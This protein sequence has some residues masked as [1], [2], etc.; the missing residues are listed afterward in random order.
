MPGNETGNLDAFINT[1]PDPQAAHAFL[2]R[3]EGSS[4][5]LLEKNTQ[6]LYHVLTLA[7]YSPF[8]AETLLRHPEHIGWLKGE[9][10]HNFDRVK[11][12]EQLSEELA[13]FVTRM[14]EA[15]DP[16]RLV[17]FK[18]RELLRIYL[19]DCL[20]VATL[21]E[22]TEELSNLADVILRHA[23]ARANQ[24]MVNLHGRPLTH[25]AR[26]RMQNA[27]FAIVA[28][29]KL[30]CRELNYSSDIDLLFLY[31]G[32]GDTS[33]DGR[34]RES[35]ISNKEFF[36]GVA[37]R[38]VRMIGKS[39]DEGAVYRIDLRLRPHGRDGDLVW[40]VNR[41]SDYY[42]SIAHNWERQA[43][44]RARLSAG[45]ESVVTRFILTV[46]DV[47][48]TPEAVPGTM[49]AV[50]RAKEKIDMKQAARARGFNVKLGPGGIREIE[51]IAQALQLK[52][53][54]RE[55]WVRS[56]QTLIVLAR[57]AEKH[58]LTEA[59]RARLSAAYTFLRTVEHRLQ[60]EHGAQTHTLPAA[61]PRLQLLA[62]RCGYTQT[63]DPVAQ[64][65][66][67][68][69]KHTAAVRA[70]YDRVF[71]ETGDSQP[72]GE[73]GRGPAIE[74][75]GVDD[76]TERLVKQTASRLEKAIRVLSP[77]ASDSSLISVLA[78]A[79]PS[80]INPLRS[81]RNLSA[82]AESL[83]THTGE[84]FQATGQVVDARDLPL[85]IQR[86][87]LVLSSQYLAHLLVSRPG[88]ATALI[89]GD[90][91]I[92]ETEFLPFLSAEVDREP[93]LASKA[94][95]LRR[96]W[97]RLVIA[98]GHKDLSAV[99]GPLSVD[100]GKLIPRN[101]QQRTALYKRQASEHLRGINLAQT[102]LAEAVLRIALRIA[103]ESIGIAIDQQGRL[104]LAILGLGRL[105]HAGMDYGSDLDLLIVFDD[106]Q[107]WPP[108]V[109]AQVRGG[110]QWNNPQEFYAKVTAHLVHV[111]SSI[112]REGLLYRSDLR[113]RPEGKSGPVAVGLGGLIAYLVSRASSWEHSAYLKAREVA[114]DLDFGRRAR[115]R[116][117]EA[118]FEA[119]SR[120]SSL[121]EE[122]RVM[123]ARIA[124]E[125]T[126][127]NRPNIKWGTGG[128]ADVYFVT[129]YL[130]L[131]DR[132]YFPPEL[133]TTA[134]IKHLG[135]LGALDEEAARSLFEGYTFLRTL[136][137]WMRLLLDR[138]SPVLPTSTIALQD[139]SQALGLPSA[140]ILEETFAQ[141][142]AAI[143]AVYDQVFGS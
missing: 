45:S 44:I 122:L 96:A 15:D 138:P 80:A 95:A 3:L 68:L 22:V 125:K 26:G 28:L 84:Q 4:S 64:F 35:V 91:P 123:R 100:E 55:P 30:G 140:E 61:R 23:L 120:N 113:L 53:G 48:F 72:P 106:E 42:R 132:I 89:E 56:A 110:A 40:E 121:R 93:D 143:R 12:T 9:T 119:A 36:T 105:G 76:E 90:S 137:H 77:K 131:R 50:R 18:R 6:L 31:S 102:A 38:V 41:A 54:G 82:W 130:Q 8:L 88:L 5:F 20:S 126:R 99:R 49:D 118:S 24:E 81:L 10:E 136:D 133:G 94:D 74:A 92:D 33:G 60:M 70:V 117:C 78:S 63:D 116:I 14:I 19:R 51:F 111:L 16:T 17:R 141:H 32:D 103:L 39:T 115:D 114:G 73:I 67:E 29:G 124:K 58:Y 59:E 107:P 79:L 87:I 142:T 98:I 2:K 37:E 139:I 27:E 134:L 1:L 109:L 97:Y 101:A 127:G 21:S 104:S 66:S 85:L 108:P 75:E 112:T 43:L 7:G 57:L 62:R 52:H 34:A 13:R 46:R 71:D 11:S 129:R 135:E 69:E 86:M 83:A 65:T 47:I 25:S 128:M